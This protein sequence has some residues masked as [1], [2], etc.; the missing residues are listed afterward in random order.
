[1][2]SHQNQGRHT[3]YAMSKQQYQSMSNQLNIAFLIQFINSR[4]YFKGRLH[5]KFSPIFT[6]YKACK[7]R[8]SLINYRQSTTSRLCYL[9]TTCL[10]ISILK[11]SKVKINKMEGEINARVINKISPNQQMASSSSRVSIVMQYSAVRI[12]RHLIWMAKRYFQGAKYSRKVLLK[13]VQVGIDQLIIFHSWTC[14]AKI[15]IGNAE[16]R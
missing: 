15:E 13:I 9:A 2:F 1:M 12:I 14:K 10:S 6:H 7:Q 3:T 8:Y 5:A 11:S 4:H 16:A